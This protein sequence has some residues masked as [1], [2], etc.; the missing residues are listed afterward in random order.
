MYNVYRL[1]RHVIT[2]LVNTIQYIIL[3]KQNDE[4]KK[5]IV[6]KYFVKKN[7]KKK[8]DTR[9]ILADIHK[10]K[11]RIA[12]RANIYVHIYTCYHANRCCR[13][14]RFDKRNFNESLMIIE[15]SYSALRAHATDRVMDTITVADKGFAIG[16]NGPSH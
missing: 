7:E 4:M 15:N 12:S 5:K 8:R 2:S 16:A 9:L 6:N 10:H 13:S 1:Y 3:N 14:K 11:Y